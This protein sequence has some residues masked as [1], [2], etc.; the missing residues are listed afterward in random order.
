MSLGHDLLKAQARIKELEASI[1]EKEKTITKLVAETA[2]INTK[3]RSPEAAAQQTTAH[4]APPLW[5][6]YRAIVD[7]VEKSRFWNAHEKEL[8]TEVTK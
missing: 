4:P 8:R 2:A 5:S 7:P 6:R 3:R 1:E